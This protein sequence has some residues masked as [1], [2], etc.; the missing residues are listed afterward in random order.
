TLVV[1][2][3]SP[4]IVHARDS[5]GRLSDAERVHSLL[6]STKGRIPGYGFCPWRSFR[7]GRR[8][9]NFPVSGGKVC[10]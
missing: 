9:D 3:R 7:I 2:P 6:E 8:K 10:E 1:G 4:F 5:I